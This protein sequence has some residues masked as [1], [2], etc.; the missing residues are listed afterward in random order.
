M[1][2][3]PWKLLL[4]IVSTIFSLVLLY[5]A[6]TLVQ[7]LLTSREHTT[8]TA[9]AAVVFGTTE[10]NG[11]PSPTL[12]ARLN[13]A[14][15]VWRSHRVSWIVVTGGK[16]PGDHFTEGGVSATYLEQ[17]GVPASKILV[18]AG[19]DTWQN[20]STSATQMLTHNIH[21]VLAI[22]DGFHEYR[23]MA[24]LSA[25]GFSPSPNPDND[26]AI[27]GFTLVKYFLKETL[28]VGVGRIVGFGTLSSWT[29]A[30]TTVSSIVKSV[31]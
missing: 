6:F 3:G 13:E 18:G 28:S 17:R 12:Q 27:S 9:D 21:T 4:K 25:Q 7:V 22:T 5:F 26:P 16:R 24:I 10:D 31:P 1:I 8:S 20:V 2:F 19:A 29:A 11:T 30:T 15:V 23:A 14:V